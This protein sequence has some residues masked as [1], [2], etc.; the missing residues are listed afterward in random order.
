M[1]FIKS[2]CPL[3][4]QHSVE[5]RAMPDLIIQFGTP[6]RRRYQVPQE[7]SQVSFLKVGNG[8]KELKYHS[9]YQ[10]LENTMHCCVF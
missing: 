10:F 7:D 3:N 9:T 6:G 1:M 8:K 5:N 4:S 2:K